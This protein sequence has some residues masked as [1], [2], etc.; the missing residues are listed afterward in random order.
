MSFLLAPIVFILGI[1]AAMGVLLLTVKA[2]R[3]FKGW[4]AGG[5]AFIATLVLMGIMVLPFSLP[6]WS[7][8]FNA[9]LVVGGWYLFLVAIGGR[10]VFRVFKVIQI[11]FDGD[12]AND[13]VLDHVIGGAD[14]RKNI[15][16]AQAAQKAG[17]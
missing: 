15:K 1:P 6:G 5:G 10:N 2:H 12:P 3:I 7:L 4:F 16:N 14:A 8:P 13:G 9:W 11:L 17:K